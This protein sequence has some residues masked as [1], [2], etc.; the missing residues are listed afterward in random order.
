MADPADTLLNIGA[1][2]VTGLV[3]AGASVRFALS[4]FRSERTWE[5]KVTAYTEIFDALY[6][7]QK[8][9]KLEVKQIEEGGE[10][11]E[12][13]KKEVGRKASEGND[14]LRLA[15]IKGT[16]VVGEDAAKKLEEL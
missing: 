10:Y 5:R 14:A 7:V 2:V 13:Y 15:A 11:D 8:G 3:T 16:F 9:A 6:H 1:G 12:D 4:R